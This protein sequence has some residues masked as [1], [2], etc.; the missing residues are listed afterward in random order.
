MSEV[1]TPLKKMFAKRERDVPTQMET[2]S[3]GFGSFAITMGD[4]SSSPNGQTISEVAIVKP[5][6][7]P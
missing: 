1:D 2:R 4:S 3:M 6:A 7:L 5:K